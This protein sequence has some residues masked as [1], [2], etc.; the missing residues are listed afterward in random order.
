MFSTDPDV[1]A[2]HTTKM[3]APKGRKVLVSQ[4]DA[5]RGLATRHLESEAAFK[6]GW[7][8]AWSLRRRLES[9]PNRKGFSALR[10]RKQ[11]REGR[12][13]KERRME[14]APLP[15]A[16]QVGNWPSLRQEKQI[17]SN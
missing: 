2:G 10:H 4:I 16:A 8:A 1:V 6:G 17:R 14:W 15:L 11:G 12:E 5:V 7:L 9:N 3:P 13:E